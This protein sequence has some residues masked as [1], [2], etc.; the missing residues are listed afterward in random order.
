MGPPVAHAPGSERPVSLY[1]LF[2]TIPLPEW[3]VGRLGKAV[4]QENGL[5][6]LDQGPTDENTFEVYNPVG[7]VYLS[8]ERSRQEARITVRAD[9]VVGHNS[10]YLTGACIE[11]VNHE[12]YGG[13]YSQMV[14]GENFQEPG[15]G[16]EVKGFK[17]FGG[18]WRVR[19]EEVQVSGSAGDKLVS[20]LPAFTEGEVGVEVFVPD[21][22]CSNTGLIVRVARPGK[23]M[24]NFDG[25]E[26]A[27]NAAEQNVR[28][29][30]HRHNW[31]AIK[32]TPCAVPTGQWVPLVVKLHGRTIEIFVSGKSIL[33]YEDGKAA[34]LSGAIGLRQFQPEARYR[35][36][37]VKTGGKT[38]MLTFES[39]PDSSLEV[40]GMWRPVRIGGATGA[41][42]L[43]RDRPFV[44]RQS[45]RLTFLQGPGEIGVENQGLNRWGMFFEEGKPY[46]G[47]LWV[48]AETPVDLYV[49]LESKDSPQP[50]AETRL[51]VKPGDWQ[52]LTFILT[53]RMTGKFGR[54]ALTLRKPGSVVLGYAFLQPGAWGRFQGLPVRRDVAEGLVAQGITVLRYGGSM[55]N[56]P[57]YRWKKMI[58]PR[59]RRP[60]YN[61]T[62]YPYSTNGWGI[63]D[64]LDLCEA[65]G[66]LGIPAF[67]LD[68]T[69][70]DMAR[71]PRVRER[72]GYQRV[73]PPPRR[74]RSSQTLPP[75]PPGTRQ[76]RAGGREIFPEV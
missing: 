37:W 67:H 17:A 73:G 19:G 63:L 66:F 35:K 50:L 43:E 74:R 26:I 36:L 49:V 5:Q 24:D 48:R 21:R 14:F 9:R 57:D 18:N 41:F 51:S 52:R 4:L 39:A 55:V 47:I 3:I 38:Q 64:F 27:L 44:G 54:L 7:R 28:L 59:D 40:S 16:P 65:A 76:R 20:E 60:P 25:Y 15:T 12:I 75:A 22:H 46:E 70:Q 10:R 68:E 1:K 58:G 8:S 72:P 69:P 31:E 71:L 32:D 61:G 30:R 45:Q 53:P 13:I 62:W 6:L 34:L 2:C 23:G 42:A 11:D 29:G 56:H 33:R